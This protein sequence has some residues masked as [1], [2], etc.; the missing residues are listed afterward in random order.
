[1]GYD[2]NL[3][4]NVENNHKVEEGGGGHMI[5]LK[6]HCLFIFL[7]LNQTLLLADHFLETYSHIL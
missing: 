7:I 4:H 2:R 6:T 5:C 3:N 1:M